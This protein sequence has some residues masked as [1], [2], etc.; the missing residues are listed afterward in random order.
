MALR[1]GAHAIC[2]KP[3]VLNPRNLDALEKMEKESGKK[4]FNV[5]QLRLHESI[6]ELGKV[7]GAPKNKNLILI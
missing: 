3:L 6:I 5:L 2:E 4:I 7:D 1:R